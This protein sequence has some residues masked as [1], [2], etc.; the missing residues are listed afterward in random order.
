M[1]DSNSTIQ[2]NELEKAQGIAV[3]AAAKI[4]HNGYVRFSLKTQ[5]GNIE[6][7][8]GRCDSLFIRGTP[9]AIIGFGLVKPEWLPGQATTNATAQ[10]VVFEKSGPFLT[11]GKPK[12]KRPTA[13]RIIIRAWGATRRTVDV[14]VPITDEQKA[15][16]CRLKTMSSH[17]TYIHTPVIREYRKV[18]N[19][20]YLN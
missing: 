14:Q 4:D 17:E 7:E 9:E 15:Q 13:P 18:G 12:G 11:T 5:H 16:C 6:V 19:V 3:P 2:A 20:I 10:Q 1:A 8:A